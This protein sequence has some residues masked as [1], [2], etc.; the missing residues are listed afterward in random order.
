[1]STAL[2]SLAMLLSTLFYGAAAVLQ[3]RAVRATQ[4][5]ASLDPRFF[6]TLIHQPSYL[7]ALA[8]STVG[9]AAQLPALRALPLFAVQATQAANL[10]VAAV[11]AIPVLKERLRVLDWIAVAASVGGLCLLLMSINARYSISAKGFD[12]GL[13]AWAA[14]LL[15]ASYASQRIRGLFGG[16]ILGFMAGLAFGTVGVAVK[17]VRISSTLTSLLS[18]PPIYVLI[19]SGVLAFMLYAVALD[20]STVTIATTALI[21]AQ[22][23]GSALV[24]TFVLGDRTK[25]GYALTAAFGLALAVAGAI[26]LARYAQPS[27]PA[28]RAD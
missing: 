4:N 12:L 2:V 13:M 16:A 7:L 26:V 25:P 24:G 14:F 22:V 9:F 27:E 15:T 3:A 10:A 21:V 6:V 19:V 28:A 1:M 11:L 23:G 18:D 5:N 8:F 20:R 17:S